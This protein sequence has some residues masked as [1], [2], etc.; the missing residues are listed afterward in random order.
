[1]QTPMLA[2]ARR[3]KDAALAI[4]VMA[5]PDEAILAAWRRFRPLVRWTLVR[6]LGPDD[7]DV[8]DLSQEA[9]LQLHRS[10][11]TLRSPDAIR[12]FVAGIAVRLAL[13]ENRR[14]RVRGRQVLVP[15]Q[16]LVPVASAEPDPEARQAMAGLLRVVERLRPADQDMFVLRQIEGL[17]QAEIC[18]IT[19]MSIS[20]VRRRLRRLERRIDKL[21]RA[22]PALSAYAERARK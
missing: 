22:D 19:G 9:F 15:G 11:R 18:D 1:M 13:Q 20:T 16:G 2:A 17:D 14:R 6:M 21:A 3:A 5:Q 4:R 7:E 10:V 8:R 12:S